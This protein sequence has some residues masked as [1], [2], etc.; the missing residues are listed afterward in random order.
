MGGTAVGTREVPVDARATAALRDASVDLARTW[1]RVTAQAQADLPPM[2]LAAGD[3]PLADV[4]VL[5]G[6]VAAMEFELARRMHAA[7]TAGSLPLAGRGAALTARAWSV[8]WARRLA[9]A[10]GFAADH[11]A[12]ARP[13]AAGIITSEHVDAVARASDGLLPEELAAVLDELAA[14]WGIWSP[15]AMTRFV[16]SAVAMLHP[17][18]DDSATPDESAAHAAR[19]LSFSVLGD[20]VQFSGELPRLEG[21]VVMAAVDAFA[22]RLRSQAD[23]VPSY[24]RRADA[25]VELV[26]VAQAADVLPSRGGLPVG[27]TV[28]ID[29]TSCGDSVWTTSRGHHLTASERA[30]AACDAAITPVLVESPPKAGADGAD[31]ADGAAARIAALAALLAGPRLPLAAGRTVRTATAVQR[32]A[33]AV[34]DRGCII[35]ACETPP[36]ACQSHHLREWADGGT[37]DVDGMVLLCWTHHRQVDL[38]MWTIEPAVG[39]DAGRPPESPAPAGTPWAGNNGA[40]WTIT[41]TPRRSWRT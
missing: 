14:F 37:T 38:R 36:E 6:C 25:L 39:D 2:D 19:G 22:D 8:P 21:E 11:P 28:T 23:H 31:G 20:T 40:P 18:P 35:P 29:R 41:R 33:L 7:A 4:E 1:Q 27:L 26:S 30:F 13:W 9:R 3:R 17:P 5:A 15:A 34:R 16:R 12:I 24:A 10:G 32:R